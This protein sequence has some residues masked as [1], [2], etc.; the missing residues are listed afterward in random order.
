MATYIVLSNF[1][2][3]GIRTVKDTT[4][5][6]AAVREMAKKC[7]IEM[8][9]IYW[10]LGSHDLVVTFDAPDDATFTAFG[11]SLGA[12]GNVRGCVKTQNHFSGECVRLR[13]NLKMELH[14]ARR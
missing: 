8:K 6:A 7:G 11:L 3:Q 12:A 14:E 9:D 1:T 5:R 2:Y 13:S 4:K 10:T